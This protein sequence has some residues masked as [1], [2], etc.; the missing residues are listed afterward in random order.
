MLDPAQLERTVAELR[1]ADEARRT[2][3]PLLPGKIMLDRLK[4][5][6][7]Y[8]RMGARQGGYTAGLL[9]VGLDLVADVLKR[10]LEP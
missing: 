8:A 4:T 2:V 5:E 1:K 9:E 10:T 3:D 6:S 7:V